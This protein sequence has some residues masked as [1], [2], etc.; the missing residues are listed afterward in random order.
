MLLPSEGN[1]SLAPNF[2]V[3]RLPPVR[4]F[5]RDALRV[6]EML[7]GEVFADGVVPPAAA[8]KGC[9]GAEAVCKRSAVHARQSPQCSL[10]SAA[11]GRGLSWLT[12]NRQ[13]GGVYLKRA[14]AHRL[15]CYAHHLRNVP[16]GFSQPSSTELQ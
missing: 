14:V 15:L 7:V 6:V 2:L 3:R 4:F 5:K 11:T 1:A 8:A 12:L 16:T 13:A 10:V 9:R